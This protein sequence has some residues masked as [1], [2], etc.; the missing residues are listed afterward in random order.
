MDRPLILASGSP[1]RKELLAL[2]GLDFEIRPLDNIDEDALLADYSGEVLGGAEHMA[3]A[4]ARMAVELKV[5]EGKKAQSVTLISTDN[6]Q[7]VSVR[8][9]LENGKINFRVPEL[10]LYDMLVVQLD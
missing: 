1:R 2:T 9:T 10:K 6:P 3:K 4:K 5:P 7:T 8:F